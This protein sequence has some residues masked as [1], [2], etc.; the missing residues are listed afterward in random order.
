[1]NT[2]FENGELVQV[3]GPDIYLD[4]A[5]AEPER[6]LDAMQALLSVVFELGAW[7]GKDKIKTF[8]A[9]CVLRQEAQSPASFA[10]ENKVSGSYLR[11]VIRQAHSQVQAQVSSSAKPDGISL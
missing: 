7:A 1:M 6:D 3:V 4:E 9:R 5:E 2:A 8:A 11:R 10:R